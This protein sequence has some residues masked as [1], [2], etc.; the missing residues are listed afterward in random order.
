MPSIT[1]DRSLLF[2]I[3]PPAI[4]T[5]D[6]LVTTASEAHK[7]IFVVEKQRKAG[8]WDEA[9]LKFLRV[10]LGTEYATI[11]TAAA[12]QGAISLDGYYLFRVPSFIVTYGSW[13]D[14]KAAYD[15][16]TSG[17]TALIVPDDVDEATPGQLKLGVVG[18]VPK[19]DGVTSY[20][21]FPLD[22][23]VFTG[24]EG[25]GDPV[26]SIT[27]EF[28]LTNGVYTHTPTGSTLNSTT[29][30]FFAGTPPGVDP[31]DTII[32]QVT[33]SLAKTA[34]VNAVPAVLTIVR[35]TT[36][37]TVETITYLVPD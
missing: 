30:E 26:F 17:V 20:S 34:L 10:A 24:V 22:R 23:L 2:T 9:G 32:I 18:A 25:G 36:L 6:V 3:G 28:T 12:G 19:R 27:A 7:N 4:W 5:L 35:P 8:V 37:D 21:V 33:D 16:V 11:P 13:D 29:G 1:L 15:G 14:G 31:T